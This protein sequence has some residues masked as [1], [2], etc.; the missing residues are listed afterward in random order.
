MRELAS[1]I[2]EELPPDKCRLLLGSRALG[3]VGV[4]I[5]ALPAVLPVNYSIVGGRIVFRTAPGTKLEAATAG[6]V[7]AFEVDDY[8]SDRREG[9]SVMVRGISQEITDPDDLAAARALRLDSWALG[10]AADRFVA[11]DTTLM[12]GR[13]VRRLP[14]T[15]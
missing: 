10:E 8:N 3:R 5:G 1:P 9:W 6:T 7:V 14:P 15:T 13:R 4:S 11:I 12:T 2:F